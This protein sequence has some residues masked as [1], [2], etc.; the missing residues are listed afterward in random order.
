MFVRRD[1]TIDVVLRVIVKNII[2]VTRLTRPAQSQN[3]KNGVCL[4]RSIHLV[5]S[6]KTFGLE[7]VLIANLQAFLVTLHIN[8]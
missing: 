5:T 7:T 2:L 8:D 1:L 4:R 6:R 3:L